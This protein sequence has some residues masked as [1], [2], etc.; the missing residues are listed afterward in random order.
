[1]LF[2]LFGKSN[3]SKISAS[4]PNQPAM[5][6][7]AF[8]CK[9]LGE[10]DGKTYFCIAAKAEEH[11]IE[12]SIHDDSH[13]IDNP[14]YIQ[15][16]VSAPIIATIVVTTASPLVNLAK[17]TIHIRM[18]DGSLYVAENL[19]SC[20]ET[21]ILGTSVAFCKEA[22]AMSSEVKERY[23]Q[24]SDAALYIRDSIQNGDGFLPGYLTFRVIRKPNAID[25]FVNGDIVATIQPQVHPWEPRYKGWSLDSYRPYI[26]FFSVYLF[27]D[28]FQMEATDWLR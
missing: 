6:P 18:E 26:P 4:N 16:T 13:N 15:T 2:H 1:M 10:E 12:M 9:S 14:A 17:N 11:R 23:A 28:L 25:F 7:C 5:P 22:D 3:H 24:C 19:L 8:P 20:E 27:V 21:H